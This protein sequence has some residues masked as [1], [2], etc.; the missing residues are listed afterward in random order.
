MGEAGRVR[1]RS[2]PGRDVSNLYQNLNPQNELN[3]PRRG[4]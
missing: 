1:A 4:E 2:G 3:I